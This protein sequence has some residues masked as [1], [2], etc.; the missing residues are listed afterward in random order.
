MPKKSLVDT[1][2]HTNNTAKIHQG[3]KV[4]T[5]WNELY[6]LSQSPELNPT[7]HVFGLANTRL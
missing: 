4:V 6:W 5:K 3:K 2:R 7:K 1:Y